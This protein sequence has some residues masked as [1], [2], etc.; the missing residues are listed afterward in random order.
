MKILQK[1]DYEIKLQLYHEKKT[2]ITEE[3]ERLKTF[4]LKK[5]FNLKIK[6]RSQ[7]YKTQVLRIEKT[8]Q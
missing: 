1:K 2:D 6:N 7:K 5:S 4:L 3:V 8:N